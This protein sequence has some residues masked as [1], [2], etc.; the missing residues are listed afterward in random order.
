MRLLSR[1]SPLSLPWTTLRLA[2]RYLLPLAACFAAGQAVRWGVIWLGVAIGHGSGATKQLH[3]AGVL[4][5]LVVLVLVSVTVPILMLY[6]VR[7]GI[8]GHDSADDGFVTVLSRAVMPFVI[9]YFAWG[10]LTADA[11]AFS[12]ADVEQNADKFYTQPL[13]TDPSMNPGGLLLG[14][15]FVV[16]LVIAVGSYYL[17]AVF[18][19]LSNRRDNRA[20]PMIAAF[21]ETAFNV[22]GLMSIVQIVGTGST[23][24]TERHIWTVL[25]D[26]FTSVSDAIPGW[27]A[28][29]GMVA[30]VWPNL[31]GAV[32]LPLLWLTLASAVYGRELFDERETAHGTRMERL[33]DRYDS[34]TVFNRWMLDHVATS[35]RERWAPIGGAFRLAF[36][37][38]AV[39]VGVFCVLYI[40]I[41]AV[42]QLAARGVV[43]LIGWQ[44]DQAV[45]GP[46][47]VPIDFVRD[48]LRT[49]LQMCLLAAMFDL[50]VH[51]ER[52][53]T[54]AR[55]AAST[56]VEAGVSA[57]TPEPALAPPS[58]GHP[59]RQAPVSAG[60][61]EEPDWRRP[62]A[63]GHEAR[64][65]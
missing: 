3:V 17:R 44:Q 5:L 19:M 48:L 37:A 43:Q 11:G 26:F 51:H 53:R 20:F 61:P 12:R 57:G 30:D 23:W 29:W 33:Y 54:A 22:F 10:M 35:F 13:T 24:V 32:I 52:R 4:T 62:S 64:P 58:S 60:R 21:F 14:I 39:A 31:V 56:H 49:V 55:A 63:P 46:I 42:T 50:A 59:Y 6:S 9:I 40:G 28:F 7:R 36:R 65:W 1:D 2:G 15:S 25:T 34:M 45:W 8:A 38:G 27:N 47:M 41:D 16:A 18:E